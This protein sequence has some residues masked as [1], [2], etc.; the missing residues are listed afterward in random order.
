MNFH[1]R[2]GS[3]RPSPTNDDY[4]GKH[5]IE[6]GPLFEVFLVEET[7]FNEHGVLEEGWHWQRDSVLSGPFPTSRAAFWDAVIKYPLETA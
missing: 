5:S 7:D 6:A 4:E 2:L 1:Y 3:L